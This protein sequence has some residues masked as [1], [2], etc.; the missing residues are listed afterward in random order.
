MSTTKQNQAVYGNENSLK[1]RRSHKTLRGTHTP[2]QGEQQPVQEWP[3]KIG[4]NAKYYK[5]SNFL[6]K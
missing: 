3:R 2:E 5:E 4:C 6:S 1:G